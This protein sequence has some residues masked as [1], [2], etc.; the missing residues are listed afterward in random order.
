MRN[1][2]RTRPLASVLLFAALAAALEAQGTL[3]GFEETYALAAERAKAVETLIPGTEDWYYY[4]CRERLDARDF[5]SVQKMLAAWISAA[6]A[7]S[8]SSKSRTGKRC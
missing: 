5:A 7:P 2:H 1:P 6:V 3:V 4:H 8:A